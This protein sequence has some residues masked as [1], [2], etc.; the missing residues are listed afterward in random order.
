MCYSIK[1]NRSIVKLICMYG[2]PLPLSD[3]KNLFLFIIV[4]LFR[5]PFLRLLFHLLRYSLLLFLLPF[6]F[7]LSLHLLRSRD[8]VVGIA[9]GYGLE[10][11]GVGVRVPVGSRIFSSR[12]PDRLRLPANLLS[13]EYRGLFPRGKAA[14][15]WN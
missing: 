6:L 1:E 12:R 3:P 8:S 2:P 7:F 15:A 4:L 11:G 10:G 5:I 13:N 9:T 14:G